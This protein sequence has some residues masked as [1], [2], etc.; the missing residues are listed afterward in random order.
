MADKKQ[1][2]E[3][4]WNLHETYIE[5]ILDQLTNKKDGLKASTLDVI[6]AFL[7]D[8]AITRKEMKKT[9]P[10]ESIEDMLSDWSEEVDPDESDRNGGS[11]DLNQGFKIAQ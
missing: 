4:L 3:K 11:D 8:N 2:E 7:R 6:R 9:N 1:I 10:M 5:Y